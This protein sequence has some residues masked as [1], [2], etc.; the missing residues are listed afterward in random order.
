MKQFRVTLKNLDTGDWQRPRF[1][2][3]SSIAAAYQAGE[4]FAGQ[5][6]SLVNVEEV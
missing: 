2:A 3:P 6:Y 5:G 1:L 4:Q